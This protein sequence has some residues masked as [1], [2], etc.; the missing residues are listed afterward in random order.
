MPIPEQD[1]LLVKDGPVSAR[2]LITVCFFHK[3]T[4]NFKLDFNCRSRSVTT[5]CWRSIYRNRD[6]M[7]H[8]SISK[9]RTRKFCCA[10]P[11]DALPGSAPNNRPLQ[12]VNS[13]RAAVEELR[14]LGMRMKLDRTYDIGPGVCR[15]ITRI[16]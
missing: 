10:L 2:S 15:G 8:C 16:D 11:E 13:K 3:S 4:S 7:S 5:P 12:I 9:C 6:P 14:H 1:Q